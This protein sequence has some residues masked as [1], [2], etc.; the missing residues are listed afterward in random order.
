MIKILQ[1][2]EQVLE[3]IENELP[4]QEVSWYLPILV[5]YYLV[6]KDNDRAELCR[7]CF[8]GIVTIK[9]IHYLDTL[10]LMYPE[11][12]FSFLDEYEIQQEARMGFGIGIRNNE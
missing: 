5:D 6:S 4:A 8:V 7:K 3:D 1:I 10:M 9:L 11:E 12:I 2:C